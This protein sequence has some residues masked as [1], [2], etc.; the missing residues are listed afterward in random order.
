MRQNF[1]SGTVWEKNLSY[2]RAVRVGD[3]VKVAGTTAVDEAGNLVGGSDMY[4]Q[5]M[6]IYQK[7]NTALQQA[8]SDIS[9]VV[10]TRIY[11][12]DISQWE[13]AGR[14]HHEMFHEVHPVS[15]MVEVSALI[16]PDLLVEIEVEAM[17]HY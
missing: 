10:S 7:I 11:V 17:M 9:L 8:G 14:A 13:A 6:Y 2:S 4:A 15:T 5:C 12:T 1:S 3:M 16:R